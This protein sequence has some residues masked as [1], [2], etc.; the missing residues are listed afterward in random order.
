MNEVYELSLSLHLFFIKTLVVLLILH[1]L[2][3]FL[4]QNQKYIVRLRLF[5]P[6]YYTN[7]AFVFFTG[8]LELGILRFSLDFGIILMI[9]SFFM[10]IF[11]GIAGFKRLKRLQINKDFNAFKYFMSIKIITE[12]FII[13]LSTYVGI[14]F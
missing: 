7:L 2:L 14:K 11:L 13:I 4:K 6:L 3:V 1:L 5:L 8:A 10:L 12:C 9:I